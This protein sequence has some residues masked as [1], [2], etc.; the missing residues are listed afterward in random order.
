MSG[1]IGL[2]PVLDHRRIASDPQFANFADLK[3][4]RGLR[5]TD[6][7]FDTDAGASDRSENV[8]ADPMVV[9]GQCTDGC[10]ALG[11]AVGLVEVHARIPLHVTRKQCFGNR[12]GP[13][14]HQRECLEHLG[15]EGRMMSN[16]AVHRRYTCDGRDAVITHGVHD[17][18][19]VERRHEND[20]AAR[21]DEQSPRHDARDVEERHECQVTPSW[22]DVHRHLAAVGDKSNGSLVEYHALGKSRGSSRVHQNGRRIVGGLRRQGRR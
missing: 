3:R 21:R 14:A 1:R 22:C 8:A 17:P 16:H 5:V 19:G 4:Q 10:G 9:R 13:V 15:L 12:R 11:H 2:V 7:D 6:L 18:Y 20:A